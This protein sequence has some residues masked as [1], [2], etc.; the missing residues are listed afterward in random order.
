MCCSSK[1]GRDRLKT[2]DFCGL[3]YVDPP[4]NGLDRQDFEFTCEDV[5]PR[6]RL[7]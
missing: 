6:E 1:N 5:I 2:R 7:T 3:F 4:S